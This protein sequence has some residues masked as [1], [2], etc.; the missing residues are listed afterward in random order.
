MT[1]HQ[2]IEYRR[3]ELAYGKALS[4]TGGELIFNR[5]Y[6]TLTSRSSA[7]AAWRPC[8]RRGAGAEC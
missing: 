7:G 3:Q 5:R 6:E 8:E 4:S 1:T 2:Q